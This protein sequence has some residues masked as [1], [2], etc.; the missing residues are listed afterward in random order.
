MRKLLEDQFFYHSA[1]TRKCKN[2]M[3]WEVSLG[4]PSIIF[5]KFD[6]ILTEMSKDPFWI[7]N[8][9]A[10]ATLLLDEWL[11]LEAPRRIEN[12]KCAQIIKN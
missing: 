10:R 5:K 8:Y 11:I 6:A 1:L 3:F 2:G 4:S 9:K 12:I 7:S